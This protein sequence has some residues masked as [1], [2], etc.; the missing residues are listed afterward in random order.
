MQGDV[1]WMGA[2]ELREKIVSRE[3]SPVQVTEEALARAE[4]IGRKLN[5]FIRVDEEG[6]LRSARSAE[7]ALERGGALGPLHGVPITIKDLMLTRG[8]PM[9]AGSRAFGEGLHVTRD[10]EREAKVVTRLRRAGAIVIGK[11]NLNEFAF[12]VTGENAHFGDVPTPWNHAHMA[13]GSS[14]G[15]A[16]ALAAGIGY[17]SVGTDTRGSIRIPAANCGISGLKPTHGLVPTDQVYPLAPSL[18]H[19]GPMARS[20]ADLARMLDVMVGSRAGRYGA[21]LE[22]SAGGKR[23]GV[24]IGY[25]GDLDPEV[26][27]HVRAAIGVL[28]KAGMSVVEVQVPDLEVVLRASAVIA[29]CEAIAI[30]DDQLKRSREGYSGAVLGRL[31]KAYSFTAIDLVRAEQTRSVLAREYR[32]LFRS[33]DCMIAPTLPGLPAEIG[34]TNMRVAGG[35]DVWVVDASC[36]FMAPQNMTGTPALS[37]PCGFSR[38]GLPIGLQIWGAVGSDADVL[39]V[40]HAFQQQ[41]TWHR[42]HPPGLEAQPADTTPR[43]SAVGIPA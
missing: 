22:R 29:N 8:M 35:R 24:P 9:T 39:A 19:T 7:R 27:A 1:T 30:H 37:I 28:A 11:T 2:G 34:S 17:G 32:R 41:T 10:G 13:G 23:L 40:G 20:V 16:A 36:R 31:D 14:S 38:G 6:A 21:A 25:F 5:A 42:R 12:G 26:E 4:T 3:V 18:D 33:V 43:V 15:S